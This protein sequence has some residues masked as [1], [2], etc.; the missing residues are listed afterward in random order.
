MAEE[1]PI[2]RFVPEDQPGQLIEAEHQARYRW[3]AN[4]AVGGEVLDA[5]C[6]VGY[7]TA[8]LARHGGDRT[9]GVDSSQEAIADA[10]ARAGEL[11]EF[12]VGDLQDLP[13]DDASFDVVV[14]F[15]AIEH[16]FDRD[17]AL[18]ELRRVLRDGGLLLISS[19]NRRVFPP[20]N[21]HHV[22]EYEPEELEDA[23]RARFEQVMLYR[24]QTHLTSLIAG[25]RGFTASRPDAAVEIEVR[26]VVGGVPGHELYTLAIA[27]DRQLPELPGTALLTDVFDI[28]AWHE[29]A[30]EAERRVAELEQEVARLES[31]TRH[32]PG[33]E[34]ERP[35][36]E[37][38]YRLPARGAQLRR[39]RVAAQ[40]V[41]SRLPRSWR[42]AGRRAIT[43]A[44]A[45]RKQ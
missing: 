24:Q 19:P 28:K 36:G 22:Y 5:A 30:T 21:P 8:I 15:E 16:V 25:D 33:L 41:S 37:P 40:R 9:V 39:A 43:A 44:R 10:V 27:G 4:A 17:R 42:R 32:P 45:A 7:G 14:C 2:E 31:V 12:F 3:A 13:F 20:G 11:A 34:G 1:H 6:G 29:R 18:D 26:K 38:G 23:L 35:V